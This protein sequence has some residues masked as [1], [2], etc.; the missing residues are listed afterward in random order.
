MS[1]KSA[2]HAGPGFDI[3]SVRE[4]F[5]AL[6]REVHGQPLIYLDNAATTQKPRVVLDAI[7]DYYEQHNA[8][9]HRGVHTL[10]MEATDMYEHARLTMQRFLNAR[11]PAEII[12]T[13]GA[14]EALNIVAR[15]YGP[16]VLGP[17]KAVLVSECEHHANIVP[18]QMVCEQTGAE[19]RV[20][21]IHDDGTIQMDALATMLQSDVAIVAMQYVSN[22]LGTIHPVAEICAMARE[23]GIVTVIDAAQAAPHMNIDLQAIDCDFCAVSGH[24]M[25]GPTGI[26]V[27]CGR[28]ELLESM[29]PWL[30]GG[31]MILSVTFEKTTYN[32]LPNRLEAGTPHIAGAIGLAA[33]AAFLQATSLHAIAKHEHSLLTLATQHLQSQNDVRI[34]GPENENKAAVISFELDDIHPHDLGTVLDSFGIAIRSGH[35]CAQPLMKRLGVPATARV[36][37]GMYNTHSEVEHLIEGI[38]AA[39]EMFR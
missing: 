6:A 33:A 20:S 27:L 24:K 30:G 22:A 23:R 28:R 17:G 21:P 38:A 1:I 37:F 15:C 3:D 2:T 36:S 10:S 9:V 16:T 8:N 19:L 32:T 34:F 26:G 7:R 12:F 14:T 29:P 25:Y 5:P 39:R 31:D 4:M 11:E 13:R 35:H 18:W